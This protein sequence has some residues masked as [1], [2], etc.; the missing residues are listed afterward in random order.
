MSVLVNILH[1]L[2]ALSL[3]CTISGSKST[4]PSPITCT[5]RG[6]DLPEDRQVVLCPPNCAQKK[7]SVFGTGVYAAVSGV[8]TAAV[9]RGAIQSSGGPV[10][11]HKVQ[12][13]HNYT[14][15]VSHGVH[16]QALSRWTASFTVASAAKVQLELSSMTRST[17]L[18]ATE[19]E[20][21]L[22]K[23]VKKTPFEGNKDCQ[24]EI[25]V[26]LDSSKNI[27]LRRFNLQKNFLSKLAMMLRVGPNGP[28][29]G[30]VQASDTPTTEIFLTNYTQP[31][32]L[33]F[34][35]KEIR[36]LGGNT[37]TGKAIRHTVETFF[38]AT[39][40]VRR[41]H[42]MVIVALVDGWPSDDL[43]TA[44]TMAREAG[45]N[46]F[47]VSTAK[48]TP[49]ELAIVPD[50]DF[51]KK[52]VCRDNGFFSLSMPSWF[53]TTKHVKPLSQRLCSKDMLLCSKTCYNSI[54]L[55]FLI[56]GSSSVG[57]S[58]FRL[59]LDFLAAIARRF[60]ISDVGTHIG[61]VQF[62]YDQR[63]E[64]GLYDH[65]TKEATFK[66]L[67]DIHYMA[68]GTATGEAI[69]YT[70]NTLFQPKKAGWKNFLI[71]ITDGQSYDDVSRPALAAHKEG[72]TIFSVG[73]AWA[74]QEDIRDM[75]SEPK[76][77]HTFF[78]KDF[79]GLEK[80]THALVQQICQDFNNEPM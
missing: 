70:A 1:L 58:N 76:D 37:N 36:Y 31:K 62:T 59:V 16:S 27:G 9:H 42:P 79:T 22:K 73:V 43:E 21:P 40:G 71:V 44:A 77:S 29:M 68:G 32:D 18:P 23:P 51:T 48:P 30:V 3:I 46:V 45:I 19:P 53:S 52:A 10:K 17:A 56:D 34:A 14:G 39:A 38:S 64:F 61:A 8:C 15:S 66:A 60:D 25:A 69:T 80:F 11:V 13:R 78:T 7:V 4:V 2:G 12:G 65:P 57:Y 50:Q 33:V 54:N 74:P 72:I 6:A 63:L 47:L 75:A 5:T 67:Q 41:G 55:G 24:M 35:I 28:H 49:E 20:K 26:L